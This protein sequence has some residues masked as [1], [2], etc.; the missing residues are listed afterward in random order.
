M[1]LAAFGAA[2]LGLSFVSFAHQVL[3]QNATPEVRSFPREGHL[4]AGPWAFPDG[5]YNTLTTSLEV[6][7][8]CFHY[9]ADL[10]M[11]IGGWQTTGERTGEMVMV[12]QYFP[13]DLRIADLFAPGYIAPGHRF[14]PGV[15]MRRMT[16]E[17]DASGSHLTTQGTFAMYDAAGNL[18]MSQDDEEWQAWRLVVAAGPGATPVS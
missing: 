12:Y 17:V 11:G 15:A 6:D 18:G 16:L 3:A 2:G 14:E 5:P 9:V 1:A 7:G 8:V 13:D 4:L 10:G